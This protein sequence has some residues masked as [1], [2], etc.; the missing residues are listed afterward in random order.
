MKILHVINN[1]E[2]GGAES[3]LVKLV[4]HNDVDN[5]TILPFEAT[6]SNKG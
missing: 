1:L 5:I 4:N 6:R 3:M 2:R